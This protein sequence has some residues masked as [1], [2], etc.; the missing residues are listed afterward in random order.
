MAMALTVT[1][2]MMKMMTMT[3]RVVVAVM[4]VVNHAFLQAE[5][6]SGQECFQKNGKPDLDPQSWDPSGLLKK[7]PLSSYDEAL[8]L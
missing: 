4:L 2:T 1:M 8:K 5:L 7:I 3:M 6:A